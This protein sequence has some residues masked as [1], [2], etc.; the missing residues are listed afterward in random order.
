MIKTKKSDMT[1][2]GVDRLKYGSQ[3]LQKNKQILKIIIEL[4]NFCQ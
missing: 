2:Y 3:P 1:K 4:I